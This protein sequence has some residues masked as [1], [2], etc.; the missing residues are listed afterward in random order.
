[1]ACCALVT[2]IKKEYFVDPVNLISIS[3]LDKNSSGWTWRLTRDIWGAR[4]RLD[5]IKMA[6]QYKIS[7]DGGEG[8][9]RR[10]WGNEGSSRLVGYWVIGGTSSVLSGGGR[11]RQHPQEGSG[12]SE[13]QAVPTGGIRRFGDMQDPPEGSGGWGGR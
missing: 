11:S 13:V 12:E 9:S 3:G 7:R 2:L 8:A 10:A 1:M 6:T 5:H 4:G